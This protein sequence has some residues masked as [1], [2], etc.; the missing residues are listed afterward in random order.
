MLRYPGITSTQL[1]PV[2]EQLGKMDD[3][4]L[5]RVDI[6]GLC[7][8][9]HAIIKLTLN[10]SPW[11]GRYSAHILRQE[12]DLRI[13][14]EDESLLLDPQMDYSQVA[15]LSSE[16]KERLFAVRPTTMVCRRGSP[17]MQSIKGEL[18]ASLG[19]CETHGGHDAHFDRLFVEAREED[20]EPG[21]NGKYCS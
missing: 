7:Y 10:H 16:V 11:L 2:I 19:C 14:M 18:M 12:A 3:Q 20:M 17:K 6:D 15:G 21:E 8:I 4:L 1:V 9:I 5:A 13:F